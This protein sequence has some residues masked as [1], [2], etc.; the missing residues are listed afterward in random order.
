MESHNAEEVATVS[1][2]EGDYVFLQAAANRSCEQCSSRAG[3]ASLSSLFNFM[4]RIARSSRAELPSASNQQTL[5]L[6]NTLDL[7]VGDQVVLELSTAALLKATAMMYIFPLLLVFAAAIIAKLAW[8]ESA[9]IVA[10][11][12]GLLIGLL[13]VRQYSQRPQVI[14]QFQPKLVRKINTRTLWLREVKE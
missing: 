10:G 11:I 4:S 13:C 12:M 14:E 7:K 3:C 5:K 6:P 9:S 2:I 8:G 1:Q